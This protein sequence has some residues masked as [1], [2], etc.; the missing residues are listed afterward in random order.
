MKITVFGATGKTGKEVVKQALELGYEV[1]AFVR[2]P[3]K[4][5]ITNEKLILVKGDV[6]NPIEVDKA[7]GGSKGV[8]VALGASADMQSDIVMEKSALNIISSMKKHEVKRIIIQSSYPMSGSAE[9]IKFMK[10][11][12]MGEEQISMVKP[13]LD[14]KTKQ[15]ETIRTSGLEYTVVRPLMLTDDAK[16]GKYRVAENLDVKVGDKISRADVSDF[17]LKALTND[18][19]LNKTVTIS[20]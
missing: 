1:K 17:M 5:D 18:E 16:T 12:G 10:S 3:Q 8:I 9:G 13:V 2:N 7:V 4:L 6:T 14:D 20:Y 15:E 19:W 11:M